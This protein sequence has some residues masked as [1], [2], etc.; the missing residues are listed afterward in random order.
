MLKSA[1]SNFLRNAGLLFLTDKLRY[2]IEKFKHK[3]KN[4]SFRKQN[5]EIKL[6]PD[7]LIYESYRL[8]Y[9]KYYNG[10]KNAAQWLINHFEKHTQLTN[11]TLL[12]WGCGPGRTI[13]HFPT[14]LD[15]SNKF[16]ATDYNERSIRW[17]KEN[18]PNVSFNLNKLEAILPYESDSV[19]IIYGISIFTHYQN[20]PTLIGCRN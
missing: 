6:P 17:C 7:Y 9:D 16:L 5:P 8:D 12:D 3:S 2:Q 15:K 1:T 20:K 18:I 10:G 13:R 14:L 11:K 4:E 19:D